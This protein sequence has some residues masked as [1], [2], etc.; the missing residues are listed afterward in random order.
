M[1]KS[2]CPTWCDAALYIKL[3]AYIKKKKDLGMLEDIWSTPYIMKFIATLG[4]KEIIVRSIFSK[5]RSLPFP[6]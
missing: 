3:C 5:L 6:T 2:K 1:Y 4:N